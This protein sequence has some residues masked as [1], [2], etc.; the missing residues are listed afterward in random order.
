MTL[1]QELPVVVETTRFTV[2]P[3]HASDAVGGVNVGVPVHS[4]VALAPAAPIA[5]GC[6]ST[7]VIICD[8]V[9]E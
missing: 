8:T 9:A 2:A 4:M 1:V 6:V 3:L 5:G 7:T